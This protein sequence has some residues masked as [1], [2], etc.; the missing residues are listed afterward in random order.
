MDLFCLTN[1]LKLGKEFSPWVS[2]QH[3]GKLLTEHC[4]GLCVGVG[5]SECVF[6]ATG[7]FALSVSMHKNT[8]RPA[9]G[10]VL[11]SIENGL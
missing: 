7:L 2:C 8:E 9:A 6:S 4:E 10:S 5:G 1:H 3:S 11:K